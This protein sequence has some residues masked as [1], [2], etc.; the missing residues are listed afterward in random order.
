M[1]SI[2]KFSRKDLFWYKKVFSEQHFSK[3]R[4]EMFLR[5]KHYQVYYTSMFKTTCEYLE[6]VVK[7]RPIGNQE[8]FAQ[9]SRLMNDGKH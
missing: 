4:F 1:R 2:L 6:W 3:T 5:H 7:K 9:F 8:H